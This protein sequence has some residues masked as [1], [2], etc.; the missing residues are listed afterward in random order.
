MLDSPSVNTTGVG[1]IRGYDGAKQLR[2]RQRH[3]LVDTQGLVLRAMV[4]RAA[5][6][7]RAAVP[8]VLEGVA[9]ELP[10]L[11]HAWVDQGYTG[12]GKAWMETQL[13]WT[14]V[15]EQDHRAVKRIVRPMLGFKACE[16]V[17]YNLA[18]IELMHMLRKGHLE[19]GRKQGRTPSDQ[20][21]SFAA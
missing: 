2:G 4:H 12:T 14:N 18:G 1:S 13:D 8:L 16:T 21:Y 15:V 20:F 9:A 7:D 5:I 11:E 6:Q 10:R 3:R 19:G 17:Q